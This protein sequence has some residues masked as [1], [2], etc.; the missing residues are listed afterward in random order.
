MR[1]EKRMKVGVGKEGAE[2][3]R[4]KVGKGGML[5]RRGR[6]WEARRFY[7]ELWYREISGMYNSFLG[8]SVWAST[9]VQLG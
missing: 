7:G 4:G 3:G 5:S 1:M 9:R 6:F 2:R 8:A